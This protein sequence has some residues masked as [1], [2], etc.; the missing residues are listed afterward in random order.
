MDASQKDRFLAQFQKSKDE[1]ASWPEWMRREARWAAATL[2]VP[3]AA[4]KDGTK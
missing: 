3:R 4:N 1:V 2:P